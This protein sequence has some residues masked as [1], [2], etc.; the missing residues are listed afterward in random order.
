MELY[1]YI[2]LEFNYVRQKTLPLNKYKQNYPHI[3]DPDMVIEFLM[4]V[5]DYPPRALGDYQW[6]AVGIVFH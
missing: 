6:K 1:K 5:V 3:N 4:P 2:I